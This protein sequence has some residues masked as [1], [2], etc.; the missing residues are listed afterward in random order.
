MSIVE[1]ALRRL[2]NSGQ[3]RPP[4][5]GQ[6]RPPGETVLRQPRR[7]LPATSPVLADAPAAAPPSAPVPRE[8]LAT[9]VESLRDAG[10]LPRPQYAEQLRPVSP[11]KWPVLESVMAQRAAGGNAANVVMVTSSVSGEGKTFSSLNL[12]MSIAWEKDF[13]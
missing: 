3:A 6:S 9:T 12:A 2:Q 13:S 1:R 10:M 5:P 7:V 4:S 8:S 11:I